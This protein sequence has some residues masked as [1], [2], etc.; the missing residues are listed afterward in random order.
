MGRYGGGRSADIRLEGLRARGRWR[1]G[2]VENGARVRAL[3][4]AVLRLSI[5][6]ERCNSID[7]IDDGYV[8]FYINKIHPEF[9]F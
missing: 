1:Y 2:A 9:A 3:Q 6:C 8:K 7:R 5:V 4:V